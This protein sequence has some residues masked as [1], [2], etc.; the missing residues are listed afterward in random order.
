LSIRPVQLA[1]GRLKRPTAARHHMFG[2]SDS[3]PGL[4]RRGLLAGAAA[5]AGTA[6]AVSAAARVAAAEAAARQKPQRAARAGGR[7]ADVVVVGAGLAGLTAANAIQA[8][9]HSVSV[10]EARD[11]VGGRNLDLPL[12]PGKALEMGGQ[13]AGPGQD[14]VLALAKSLG[15]EIF[16]TFN[17][18][19][20]L[21]YHEGQLTSYTG[22]IPPANPAS[23]AELQLIITELNEMAA[24]VSSATPWTAAKAA[25]W[26]VQS[27]TAWIESQAHTEEA[28]E[29]IEL[30]I[31][32]VYG[33][34][35]GQVSLLDLLSAISGVGG[36]V[37]TLT[38]S[39]QSLRFVGGPQQMSIDLAARLSHPVRLSSPVR[40]VELGE[41]LTLH[42]E[43]AK[44]HARHAI[45]TAPKPVIARIIFSPELP[46]AYSQY[47]QRQPNGATIKIQ[48][49][50][51][52]PFWRASGLNGSVVS[53]TGPIQVVY[54]N[55]PPDGSPGVLVGFAEGNLARALFALSAEQ[56]RAEVLAS[57][58]RYFGPAALKTTGY[59][60]MVW[61]TEAFTL[62]AY[63]SF[64]P[65]GVL[66]S[67][68]AAVQGP[69][70]NVHFAGADY[71]PEWS[72]YME[73]AIRSGTAVA[74]EVLKLL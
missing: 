73:G 58:A 43:H 71:S 31:R 13:W 4:T 26:D 63:G 23:L 40:R 37:N 3:D 61:A 68:G 24:S 47:L 64:N 48:A 12:G 6:G 8:A 27:V 67:L 57:L 28:R 1:L 20:S 50:Y 19:N 59:A 72:G 53:L 49:V 45:F 21:Y 56:R 69:A 42:T 11:R 51:A 52:T 25:I 39:A 17:T 38:G 66:T 29:L 30:A 36:E 65:P 41:R 16:E 5:A 74:E 2:L 14:R 9:G 60:D 22:E 70:S 54:D 18:G 34:D 33:E 15:I 35:P 44:F 10:L 7:Q 46:P 32:A 62:G 55:S